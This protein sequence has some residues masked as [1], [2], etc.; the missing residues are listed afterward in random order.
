MRLSFVVVLRFACSAA[1]LALVGCDCGGPT[2]VACSV[3]G[4]CPSG[5]R[6]V[7]QRCSPG[8]DAGGQDAGGGED[9]RVPDAGRPDTG[10]VGCGDG[11]VLAGEACDDGNRDG[12]DGCSADCSMIEPDY[13]CPTPGSP[14]VSTVVCGDGVLGGAEACDDRN[15]GGGDG[16]SADCASVEPGW[17]CPTPGL[18]CL[19]AA[20]GDDIVAGTEECEDGNTTSGDGCSETCAFEEGFACDAG[21]GLA[22]RPVPCGDGVAEGTEQCDDGNTLLGDG[23]DPFCHR[24][25]M[26]SDGVCA[27]VCGDGIRLPGE[28]CDDGNL[29]DG[30]GCSSSC[31]LEEGFTCTDDVTLD[32]ESVSVPIVYRDFR[33]CDLAGG[34]PD[35]QCFLGSETGIVASTLGADGRPVYS[36]ASGGTATTTGAASFDQW[37]RD[38]SFAVTV[39]D[40]LTLGRTAPGTYVFDQSDFF[41]LDSRGWV[42]MGMEPLRAGSGGDHNF[43]FTSELRYWFV[44][45]GDEVLTFRGDDD[46]WVFINRRLA[47]DLGGVHGALSAGITL[48]AT[49]AATLGLTLGGVYEVVVFQAERHTTQ[50][51]YRLTLENFGAGRSICEPVCGDGIVTRDELCD[52]GVNDGSYG[53]C[54]PGCLAFGP[55]CGDAVV[56]SEEG[57][58]CD[59][60]VNLGGYDRCNPGCVLGPRCGD[61]TVQAEFGE[62]CDDGNR[63]PLDGCSETCTMEIG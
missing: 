55:R 52:D 37:Y 27:S 39:V 6:C 42:A 51:S 1:A 48:D 14:C 26:C 20:C 34:H 5:Q 38:S 13:A 57:E 23:C 31:A 56:Q 7:D 45:E 61:G 62:Q 58:E 3:D 4:D 43:H 60:G 19:A 17:T 40:R 11:R 63:T 30:D 16:C 59:D 9:A 46:V 18:R 24:E 29:R 12:G 36:R 15:T 22:C 49:A 33:G 53:H 25:P 32:P 41:P 47:I 35:F 50:S 2:P 28:A 8:A 44:Y 21:P 54:A 10:F